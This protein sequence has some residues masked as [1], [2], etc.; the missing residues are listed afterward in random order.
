MT[1]ALFLDLISVV[2]VK[3]LFNQILTKPSRTWSQL[4][5]NVSAICFHLMIAYISF[6]DLIDCYSAISYLKKMN[7]N[8]LTGGCVSV[9]TAL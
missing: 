4:K 5:L 9:V 6:I 7:M 3:R 2:L 1:K 8:F